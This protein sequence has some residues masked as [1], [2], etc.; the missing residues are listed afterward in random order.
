[1]PKRGTQPKASV[2]DP[3]RNNFEIKQSKLNSL[4]FN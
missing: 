2:G 1:M 4:D 3:S